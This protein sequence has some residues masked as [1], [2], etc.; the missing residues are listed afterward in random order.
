MARFIMNAVVILILT[1]VFQSQILASEA[2]GKASPRVSQTQIN[3]KAD[4][5]IAALPIIMKAAFLGS[6]LPSLS[7]AV[8]YD[9]DIVYSQAFGFM[10]LEKKIPATTKTIYPIGSITKVFVATMLIQLAEAGVVTL[11]MPVKNLLP[12]YQ[13]K[14]PYPGTQPTTLRQLATHTSGLPRDANI[15]FWSDYAAGNWLFSSGTT[16]MKWYAS[17]EEVLANLP[18]IELEYPPNSRYSYSNLGMAL[19]GIALERAAK[20]P[21]MEYIESRI[22]KPLGMNDSGFMLQKKK[23]DRVPTGYVYGTPASEPLIAPVWEFG[24]DIYSGGL[25]S[26]AED[27]TRLLSL[28]FQDDAPGGA[29]IIS[30]DGL[31][32]M[33]LE[34][35]GWGIGWGRYPVIEHTGGHIG[36]FAHVRA[37]PSL[38]IGIVALTNSNHPLMPDRPSRDIARSILD[39]LKQAILSGAPTSGF[40]SGQTGLDAYTGTYSLPGANAEINIELRDGH[41]Y[42]TLTQDPRFNYRMNPVG[43][44]RF[45]IEDDTDPWFVFEAD[46][47]GKIQSVRF[48]DFL[49]RRNE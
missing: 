35:I 30:A 27:M 44:H 34:S 18:Y 37:I 19:L 23:P 21:F 40:D 47:A 13:V 1:G 29:Q 15:N 24:V 16:E 49:F 2:S 33:H 31:R 3:S 48:L 7:I 20:V 25:Y 10:D 8:V 14:S 42:A 26:T 9:R 4:S 11:D 17:K 5:L 39:Q 38:K 22:L 43:N 12:E 41:L 45:G 28:Q 32:M 46:D 6:G 36:Y